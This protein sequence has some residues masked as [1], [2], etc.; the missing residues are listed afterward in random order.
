MTRLAVLEVG[1]L[2]SRW[3]AP[4]KTHD[5]IICGRVRLMGV[6][7]TFT[8]TY[9]N[10]T[11]MLG[12]YKGCDGNADNPDLTVARHHAK[13]CGYV[14]YMYVYT[15]LA[16]NLTW[17]NKAPITRSAHRQASREPGQRR[18]NTG[19]PSPECWRC[20]SRP[21]SSRDPCP[22]SLLLRICRTQRHSRLRP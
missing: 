8:H 18:P 1:R 10:S 16:E 17:K 9:T 7:R 5:H 12:M 19:A 4:D 11:G 15:P 14:I 6:G 13:V 21:R 2:S 3:Y 20:S 22:S